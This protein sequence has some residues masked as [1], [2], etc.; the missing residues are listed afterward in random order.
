MSIE[1][2]KD[3][4]G[5][6]KRICP[7]CLEPFT[8]T[9]MN[10]FYCPEKNGIKNFCKHRQKRLVKELK[11]DGFELERPKRP[12]MK[13]L[14]EP[15]EKNFRNIDEG[16]KETLLSRNIKLLNELLDGEKKKI[17]NC[18]QLE[19]IGFEFESFEKMETNESGSKSP[20]YGEIRLTWISE[21]KV[22]II[23]HN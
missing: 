16:I 6:Y 3:P 4:R 15:S 9:H 11:E 1:H 22:E 5:E 8:A 10:R 7:Y 21:N 13:L 18:E 12:P 17:V 19:N 20:I 23:N 2:F 14:Y